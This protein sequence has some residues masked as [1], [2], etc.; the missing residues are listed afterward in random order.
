MLRFELVWV[1]WFRLEIEGWTDNHKMNDC[2]DQRWLVLGRDIV[3]EKA[4]SG[5]CGYFVKNAAILRTFC[6]K[7]PTFFTE[8]GGSNV[9]DWKPN[10][11]TTHRHTGLI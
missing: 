7:N 10:K 2:L 8:D 4:A 6:V 1:V 3:L 5:A 9:A 11:L